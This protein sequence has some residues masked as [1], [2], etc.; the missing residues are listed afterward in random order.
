MSPE[1][2][3]VT[4]VALPSGSNL[5]VPM[6]RMP[7]SWNESEYWIERSGSTRTNSMVP[8]PSVL[9]THDHFAPMPKGGPK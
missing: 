2:V 1:L 5:N 8:V 6:E 3:H 9:L 4:R 7:K